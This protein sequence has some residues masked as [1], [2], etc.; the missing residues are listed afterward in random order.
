[1]EETMPDEDTTT[2]LSTDGASRLFS[3]EGVLLAVDGVPVAPEPEPIEN[4]EGGNE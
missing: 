4:H 1:M 3:K 2:Y